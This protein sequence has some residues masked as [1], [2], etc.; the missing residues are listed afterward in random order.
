MM[1][2]YVEMAKLVSLYIVFRNLVAR[3][4]IGGETTWGYRELQ[5]S[6]KLK[7]RPWHYNCLSSTAQAPT[8][9]VLRATGDW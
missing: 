1:W 8:S 3:V 9:G 5:V 7:Y 6:R 2:N 4:I